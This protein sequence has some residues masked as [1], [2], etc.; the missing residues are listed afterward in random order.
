[1]NQIGIK[2]FNLFFMKYIVNYINEGIKIGSNTKV[3]NFNYSDEEMRKDYNDVSNCY[4]KAEKQ[5]YARK[6]GVNS[7]KF[8]E[9]QLVIL[10]FLRKNRFK[11]KDYDVNDVRDFYRIDIPD[12]PYRK[13][14]DFFDKE[15]IEFIEYFK[16]FFENESEHFKRAR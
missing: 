10:D 5:K 7:N 13:S 1:M 14:K 12:T 16:S 11:K 3:N 2:I 4:T 9:I 8:R 6:Y 15:P